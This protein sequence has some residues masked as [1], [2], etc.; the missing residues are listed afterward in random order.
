ME[1]NFYRLKS[2]RSA[3]VEGHVGKING[4]LIFAVFFTVVS[5][6]LIIYNVAVQTNL[7]LEAYLVIAM[8]VVGCS[9]F[10]GFGI[11]EQIKSNKANAAERKLLKNCICTDGIIN[12]C[13]CKEYVRT[14]SRRTDSYYYK[15]SV[16][17][18]FYDDK[19]RLKRRTFTNTYD[20]DPEFYEGQWLMVAFNDTDSAI[21]GSF[22]FIKEDMEKFLKNEAERSADDFDNLD[23]ELLE[24]DPSKKIVSA[25]FEYAWFWAAVGLFV[26]LLAYTVPISICATPE[27]VTGK[28]IPDIFII[29]ILYLLPV[30]LTA[31]IVGFIVQYVKKRRYFKKILNNN[32][33]FTWGKIFASEK[34]YT[35]NARKKVFYCYIDNGGNRYT[36]RFFGAAVRKAVH[37][38]P[39]DV[40]VM[41]DKDGNSIPLYNYKFVGE[42]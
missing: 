20:Y 4:F 16:Q 24:V 9:A 11:H 14:H 10:L 36:K 3:R 18:S 19:N 32:P 29:F 17:Y 13:S 42:D 22:S 8:F 30:F 7:D 26:F 38:R 41:Y 37:G 15:V 5:L 25:E 28:I 39:T 12:K 33:N 40:A 1:D 23:G 31:V 21:L 35:S 6:S 34:T 2:S 27:L